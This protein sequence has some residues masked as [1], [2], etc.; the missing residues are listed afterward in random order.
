MGLKRY[1]PITPNLRH[2]VSP[3][4]SEITKTEPEKTLIGGTKRGKG[5]G[6][7]SQ[8]R[9]TVRHRGGGTKRLYREIDFK[10]QKHDVEAKVVAIEYDP[11]RSARIALLHYVDG[12]KAY[13]LA[14]NGLKVGDRVMAGEN[15]EYKVGNALPIKSIPVGTIIHNVELK[16]G[17]GGQLA[18]SAGTFAKLDGKEG[19]YAVLRLPSGEIRL[20]L[21][22]CFATIGEVGNADHSNLVYGGAGKKRNCGMRPKVRGV[23]MNGRGKQKGYKTPVSPSGVPAKG[24]K[25]RK[26]DKS[27]SQ[28]ILAKRKK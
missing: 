26:K 23:A 17:K 8:G 27:S 6:R 9:I 12:V 22:R 10:R 28:Y 25:T 4:F 21:Q 5:S 24:Y 14:P 13:I 2:R 18:R 1:K 15:A 3:D 7:N 20:V 11:N 19:K 16:P